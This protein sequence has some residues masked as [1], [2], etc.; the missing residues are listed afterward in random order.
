MATSSYTDTVIIKNK[1]TAALLRKYKSGDLRTNN[2][3]DTDVDIFE[4]MRKCNE[5]L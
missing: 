5:L 1:K 3:E 2:N 4:E